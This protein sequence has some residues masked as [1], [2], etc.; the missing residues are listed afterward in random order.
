MERNLDGHKNENKQQTNSKLYDVGTF[1]SIVISLFSFVFA[2][3]VVHPIIPFM[4]HDYFDIPKD[5][6]RKVQHYVIYLDLTFFVGSIVSSII[7]CR[8]SDIYGRR[9][10]V[11]IGLVGICSCALC[12]GLSINYYFSL[13]ISFI[14]GIFIAT[15]GILTTI[16]GD[17]ATQTN[18]PRLYAIFCVFG[19][20]GRLCGSLLGGHLTK[21]NLPFNSRYKYML[22][23]LIAC[24]ACLTAFI[25]AYCLLK[26]SNATPIRTQFFGNQLKDKIVDFGADAGN[27]NRLRNAMVQV[28]ALRWTKRKYNKIVDEY[29]DDEEDGGGTELVVRHLSDSDE[30]MEQKEDAPHARKAKEGIRPTAY[31][32]Q[33]AQLQHTVSVCSVFKQRNIWV[34]AIF[35]GFLAFLCSGY[36]SVFVIWVQSDTKQYGLN[37]S[38]GSIASVTA[39]VGPIYLLFQLIFFVHYV[40]RKGYTSI[41][42]ISLSLYVLVMLVLP[43]LGYDMLRKQSQTTQLI[44]I[45]LFA[46]IGFCIRIMCLAISIVFINASAMP[47]ERATANGIAHTIASLNHIL[48]PVLLTSVLAWSVDFNVWPFNYCLAFY[49]QALVAVI[50]VFWIHM[51]PTLDFEKRC[52]H[53]NKMKSERKRK[54]S[55]SE[56]ESDSNLR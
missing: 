43:H 37:W 52:Q 8:L 23:C 53:K 31:D 46:S 40:K 41:I 42:K 56:S 11:L 19:G 21:D 44:V 6:T 2:V 26:E 22:P 3:S 15:I 9:P 14:W 51:L 5:N 54:Q 18:Q 25:V 38:E 49:M 16:L 47:K 30:D 48:A 34:S 45:S 50:A 32:T 24:I 4:I 33:R 55:N 36:G 20:L 7:W 17:I 29:D 27:V 1:I 13:C 39:I 10:M 35:F 12:A 28:S